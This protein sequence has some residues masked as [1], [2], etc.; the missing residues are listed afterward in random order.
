MKVFEEYL[1]IVELQLDQEHNSF[2]NVKNYVSYERHCS[3]SCELT[4]SSYYS[5]PTRKLRAIET[6]KAETRSVEAYNARKKK[7]NQSSLN[8]HSRSQQ[9]AQQVIG[10]NINRIEVSQTNY[11]KLQF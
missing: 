1:K 2:R 8:H 5:K 7:S 9:E 3:P 4:D 11:Q 6:E 10:V